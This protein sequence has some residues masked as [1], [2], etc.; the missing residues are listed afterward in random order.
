MKKVLITGKNSYIGDSVRDYLLQ[1]PDKYVV[2]IKDTVGWMPRPEEFS[3]YDV[4]FNVTGIA[5]VKETKENRQ[6]YYLVNR[7]LAINIAKAAKAGGVKQLILLSS[8]SVY[9]MLVGHIT[10]STVPNPVNAYGD[11]KLQAD[12]EIETLAD[13]TFKFACLRPPMVYGRGCKGNY[14]RL[15]WVALQTFIFPD[16]ENKRSMLYI[17]NLCEFVKECI[18]QERNGLFFPQNESYVSTSEMV[19]EI[20]MNH[21]KRIRLTSVLNW[22]IRIIPANIFKKVFGNLTYEK[23]DLVGK[24]GFE[25]SISLT[26]DSSG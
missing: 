15:R 3:A 22:A 17:G 2:D 18:D 1:E 20:A 12:R 4:V 24:I 26:E 14:Q 23:V 25:E 16:H 19:R 9:G 8:M 5:H 13:D 10:K 7:D 21:A 6:K 11:S